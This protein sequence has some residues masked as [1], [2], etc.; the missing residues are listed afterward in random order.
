[1]TIII[2]AKINK[3]QSTAGWCYI[4][5]HYSQK[6]IRLLWMFFSYELWV[7]GSMLFI[8][9]MVVFF[10]MI[11]CA[12]RVKASPRIRMSATVQS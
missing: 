11:L 7:S 2:K 12:H 4:H 6:S 9:T 3:L 5:A 8:L 10:C 1:M